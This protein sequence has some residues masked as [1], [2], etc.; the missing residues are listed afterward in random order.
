MS[1]ADPTPLATDRDDT[2][3]LVDLLPMIRRVIGA[4]IRDPHT[5]EDLGRRP[6]PGSSRR[7]SASRPTSSRST[8]R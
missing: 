6:W 8:R 5:V 7:M 2:Q 3:E 4:R 1:E